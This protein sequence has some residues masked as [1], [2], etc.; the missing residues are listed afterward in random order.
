MTQE[1]DD[2]ELGPVASIVA[3]ILCCIPG[4]ITLLLWTN[5][6]WIAVPSVV[7]LLTIGVIS[8]GSCRA[9]LQRNQ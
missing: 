9:A 7:W 1:E 4:L 5:V 3:G 8:I 2:L 6:E